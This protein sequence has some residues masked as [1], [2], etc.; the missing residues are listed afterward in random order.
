MAMGQTA[1]SQNFTIAHGL[2]SNRIYHSIIDSDGFLWLSTDKG[3]SRY[4]GY[5]FQN[6]TTRD[7]LTDNEVFHMFQDSK[8]RIWFMAYNGK[9]GYYLDG[10]FYNPENT[11]FLKNAISIGMYSRAFED[12]WGNIVFFTSQGGINVFK[13]GNFTN[14]LN[15]ISY[16]FPYLL[17]GELYISIFSSE[18]LQLYLLNQQGGLQLLDNNFEQSF[19]F[20]NWSGWSSGDTVNNFA[21]NPSIPDKWK[22]ISWPKQKLTYMSKDLMVGE[23]LSPIF[24]EKLGGKCYVGTNKGLYV[25]TNRQNKLQS[26]G[27]KNDHITSITSDFEG[28]LWITT[29]ERGIYFQPDINLKKYSEISGNI[30]EIEV[31]PYNGDVWAGNPSAFYRINSRGTK[32]FSLPKLK[33]YNERITGFYFLDKN[34]FL[35]GS[36]MCLATMQNEKADVIFS[37]IA[38]IKNIAHNPYNNTLLLSKSSSVSM[39]WETAKNKWEVQD[40]ISMRTTAVLAQSAS[41]LLVGSNN[42]LYSYDIDKKINTLI[43]GTRINQIKKD[44]R[45]NIWCAS[46]VSGLYLYKNNTFTHFTEKDGLHVATIN[47]LYIDGEQNVW[48]VSPA[49]LMKTY[50]TDGKLNVVNYLLSN[51]LGNEQVNDVHK[52]GDTVIVASTAGLYFFIEK[53]FK[54]EIEMPRLVIKSI[55]VGGIPQAIAANFRLQQSENN[56]LIDYTGISYSSQSLNY[57]YKVSPGTEDWQY[58]KARTVNLVDL[59]PGTYTFTIQ[60]IK[61]GTLYSQTRQITFAI[62][63]PFYRAWW[64]YVLMLLFGIIIL[65]S[66]IRYRINGIRRQALI[67][68]IISESKQKALRAQMNPHF[69]FNSLISIQSFFLNNRNTEGQE[70]TSKFSKLIRNILDNSDKELITIEDEIATLTN[71]TDLENIRLTNPFQFRVIIDPGIDAANTLIPTMLLQPIVENSIWHGINYLQGV[72]GKILLRFALMNQNLTITIED[73]G[74]GFAQSALLNKKGNHISKGNLLIKER[75]EAINLVLKNKIICTTG[76]KPE[77]GAIVSLLIPLEK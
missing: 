30:N 50:Y 18:G 57:R 3:I 74:V 53:Q 29:L 31:N 35:V 37:R 43:L 56:I 46:D 27:Y 62:I 64:F 75:L 36:D 14:Y 45:G 17:N 58:T 25:Y 13:N 34:N 40:L 67:S 11:P 60:A 7:G 12:K 4:D 41:K 21:V 38:G 28:N 61:N 52:I 2:P 72:Q 59:P 71:Y 55:N 8:K 10:K 47:K 24:V 6:F 5:S 54:K 32:K 73:N 15:N 66:I 20:F 23:G 1:V 44:A 76:D 48:L 77:G 49:G 70:Y 22:V 63:P 33:K 65:A 9:L 26:L 19:Q 51:I 42:G 16:F 39:L 69:L 68:S